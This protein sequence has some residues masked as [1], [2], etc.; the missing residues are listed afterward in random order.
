VPYA[1]AVAEPGPLTLDD[2]MATFLESGVAALA[3]TADSEQVP[4]STRVWGCSVQPGSQRLRILVSA[5]AEET[6]YNLATTG[7]IAACFTDVVAYR[8]VQIKGRVLELPG[9]AGLSDVALFKR[10]QD[11]FFSSIEQVGLGYDMAC[12][13]RP[14]AVLPVVIDVRTIFDQTPGPSAGRSLSVML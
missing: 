4:D 6:L 14:E 10:Y 8:S 1:C 7:R 5:A 11:R 9:K 3:A 12:G 2:E 13:F